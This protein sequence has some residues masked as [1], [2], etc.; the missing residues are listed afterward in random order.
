MKPV[1]FS[2]GSFPVRSYGVAMA[3]AF[4]L[5][6]WLAR[7]RARDQGL[8]PDTIIDFSFYVIVLSIVGA[9]AVFVAQHWS[10][11]Q[12]HPAGIVRIWDGGL[13]Q[14]GGV[15]AGLATGLIYF[16]R[17]GIDPWRGADIVAPSVALGIAVGRIGCFLNGCCF[18][19]PCSLPWAVRFPA[20]SHAA[21]LFPGQAVHPT[22]L[23]ESGAALLI[24]AVLLIAD[25]RKPFHGF[26]LWFFVMLLAVFR[27]L[28]D[29][30]R[31]YGEAS[32][33][34]RA[35]ETAV[36]MNQLAGLILIA[37][38]AVFMAVL[39]RRGRPEPGSSPPTEE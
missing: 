29:P 38:A 28:V 23:Y 25:R 14:Y 26:T 32:I 37:V 10:Y 5:G 8:D 9:R 11:F 12:L 24:L 35:G 13:A 31:Q 4:L 18:G 39:A 27:F 21:E 22:Q 17:K 1:L 36:T 3:L 16:A 20:D 6:I 7:R 15:L 34:F 2:I 30:I 19:R 33:A